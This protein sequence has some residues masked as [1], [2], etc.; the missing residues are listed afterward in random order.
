MDSLARR[1]EAL[2]FIATQPVPLEELALH[3]GIRR[4]LEGGGMRPLGHAL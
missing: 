3:C 1:L 2:I 4:T